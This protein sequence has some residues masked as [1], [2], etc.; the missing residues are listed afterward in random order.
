MQTIA[1]RELKQLM[2]DTPLLTTE[3]AI[4]HLYQPSID[5]IY[6]NVKTWFRIKPMNVLV[7]DHDEQHALETIDALINSQRSWKWKPFIATSAGKK[8]ALACPIYLT[9]QP[10][11]ALV[12]PLLHLAFPILFRLLSRIPLI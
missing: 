6:R 9:S 8:K 5:V 7:V 1:S 10:L 3:A 4:T 2:N 11:A 12:L